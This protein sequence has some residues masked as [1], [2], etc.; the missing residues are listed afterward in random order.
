MAS[1]NTTFT[2]LVTTTLRERRGEVADNV[3]NHIPFLKHLRE[4]GNTRLV[5]GGRTIVEPL[6]YAENSTFKWYS[7]S[8]VLDISPSDVI[9]AAEFNWKQANVNVTADGLELHQNSGENAL[10]DLVST[11]IM[12]AEK[13]FMNNISTG[14][15]SDGTGTSGK[16][17]DG[18]QALV[19][20]DP[21][22]GTVGGIDR[23]DANNTFWRSQV[24]DATTDG[25]AATDA[26]NIQDYFDEVAILCVRNSDTPKLIVTG[27]TYFNLFKQSLVD[28]QRITSSRDATAGFSSLSY[29]GPN[30]V[31]PVMYD[32][33]CNAQR[34]YFLNT[35]YIHFVAHSRRNFEIDERRISLN[36]DAEVIPLFFM[37]NMT[38]SNSARQGLLKE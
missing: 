34:A 13:T 12:A 26:T 21:T 23:S 14:V 36:Q 15:F 27:S 32:A 29:A 18:L 8:E 37:G 9:S 2:E 5:D 4:R 11:R 20:D 17:L 6:L 30:F 16:Q 38:L 22:T 31:A 33:D 28:I 1:P 19:P 24:Y 35:D 10:I 25:G 7:G 3:L